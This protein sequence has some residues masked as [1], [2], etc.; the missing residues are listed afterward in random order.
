[1]KG[2][3]LGG[4]DGL[5]CVGVGGTGDGLSVEVAVAVAVGG[6]VA[7]F[8]GTGEAAAPLPAAGDRVAEGRGTRVGTEV[9]GAAI[10]C[11]TAGA[12]VGR[13]VGDGGIVGAGRVGEAAGGAVGFFSS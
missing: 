1:V 7:V 12:S 6:K 3:A 5:C 11:R 9:G 10:G 8:V 13:E 4:G 2:V